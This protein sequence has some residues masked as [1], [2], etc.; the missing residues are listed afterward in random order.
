MQAVDLTQAIHICTDKDLTPEQQLQAG[1]IGVGLGL[2]DDPGALELA[3]T[4]WWRNGSVLSVRFLGGDQSVQERIEKLAHQW[5]DYANVRFKFVDEGPT[6]IRIGFDPKGGSW[7]FLG[8]GNLL[9]WFNQ[10]QPTMNYGWLTPETGDEEYS[11]VVLHEFGHALG[12]IHEHQH[13]ENGIPWDKEKAYAYYGQTNGWSRSQVDAQVFNRYNKL[14]TQYSHYDPTS[15]MQYP[16]PPEI[17]T[18]GFTVGWNTKLS[19][20]DRSFIG[21]IYPKPE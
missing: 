7:S 17:T 3:V 21:Q 5:E 19:D 11:R 1:Q 14:F 15:I 6:V 16:I 12:C 10:D 18:N 20:T 13:P 9:H 4:Q 8:V 2:V